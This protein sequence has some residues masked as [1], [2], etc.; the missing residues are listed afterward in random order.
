MNPEDIAQILNAFDAKPKSLR[1]LL[2]GPSGSG[3]TCKLLSILLKPGVLCWDKLYVICKTLEQP[4][5]DLLREFDRGTEVVEFTNRVEDTPG[6]DDLDLS[7]RNLVVFDDVMLE[8]QK[9][10]IELYCHGRHANANVIFLAQKYTCVPKV[11]RENANLF[12]LFHNIDGYSIQCM[13]REHCAGDMKLDEFRKFANLSTPYS[14][15]V[16]DLVNEKKYRYEF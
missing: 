13:H 3:K 9:K 10:T 15:V 11:V 6:P 4:A 16:I 12:L 5:Y 1:A 8:N 2:I 14:F 7:K